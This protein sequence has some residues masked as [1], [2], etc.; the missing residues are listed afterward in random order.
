M[1]PCAV[2]GEPFEPAYKHGH[3]LYCSVACRKLQRGRNFKLR[4]TR[5]YGATHCEICG[6][7]IDNPRNVHKRFCG[8]LCRKAA[9]YKRKREKR[10]IGLVC[11]MCGQPLTSTRPR[12]KR[13]CST[14][15]AKQYRY[16][17]R[18]PDGIRCGAFVSWKF[19]SSL[20]A[21]PIKLQGVV[22]KRD[23]A[24]AVVF[25]AGASYEVPVYKLRR[26]A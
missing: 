3:Q 6:E 9:H 8:R 16:R 15:C 23:R 22:V 20:V 1:K 24:T 4:H 21:H 12:S 14:I 11:K 17:Q 18:R 10:I 26:A 2:C 7:P 5:H 25:C 13:F 19:G